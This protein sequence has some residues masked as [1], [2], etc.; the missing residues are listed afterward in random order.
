MPREVPIGVLARETGV[1]VPTIR[2]YESVGLLPEPAAQLIEPAHLRRVRR[3][4]LEL[5][6]PCPRAGL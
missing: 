3:A 6:P 5:H 1:K 2:Y 4:T